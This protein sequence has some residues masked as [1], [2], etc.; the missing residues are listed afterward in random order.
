M[1]RLLL[2]V[3]LCSGVAVFAQQHYWKLDTGGSI[4]WTVRP[5]Q[6]HKDHIEMS[7]KQLSAIVHYG[8]Q[9][10]GALFLSR[11]LVFPM[12][13]TI[14]NDTR[15]N[16]VKEFNGNI[17]DS[18]TIDGRK[19]TEMPRSF[20]IHG[21]LQTT[22]TL[23]KNMILERAVFP[24]TDHAAYIE[25]YILRNLGPETVA[26]NVPLIDS[27]QITDEK[28][29]VYGSYIINT[30]LYNGGLLTLKPQEARRF[31]IVISARKKFEDR[32]YYSAGY[33]FEKRSALVR[34]LENQLILQSPD[35]VINRMFAFAKIRAA[36]SIYETK[37]GLMHGPGGG[38]Y[39]AAIWANDQAEYI[40]P[41]FAYLGN[42][43]GMESARN[44]YRLFAGYMNPAYKPIP[45]SIIAEGA[46]YWNGAGD[47]GD[48]AMIGYGASQFALT[49]GDPV[50]AATLWPLIEWCNTYLL[51]KKTADG[52]I[53]SQSDE[54]EGR[55]PAGKV[56]LSTNTLAY[57]SFLYGS[58]LATALGKTKTAT[59]WQQEAHALRQHMEQYFGGTVEGYQTYKYYEGND[60]LRSWICLPLVMGIYD[61][62]EQ[63]QAALLSPKLWSPNGLLTESGSST[64]WDRSTLYAFRGLFKAGATDTAMAY[65]SF[66]SGKRLLGEHVP[67]AIEAWPEGNQRH[68]S[69]ESGL[70]CRALVEGLLGF[71]PTGFRSFSICPWLPKKWNR[72][73]LKN[74]AAFRTT[75]DLQV[76]RV[77]GKY[78]VIFNEAGKKSQIF[79]WSGKAPL[80]IT[81]P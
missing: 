77:S 22:G 26:V 10:S 8:V 79:S 57:G 27:N 63:T 48:Q 65:L 20:S 23:S 80:R 52:V 67:Y 41:F 3:L 25:S 13:R 17:A 19:I 24:S 16:L 47:R 51:R 6:A 18:I 56:N 44:S 42:A 35:P 32:Y 1:R 45:S 54:L 46:G 73:S 71:E 30:K 68:L 37:E 53:A 55:F 33:E 75:F 60:K 74:I 69:A 40:N 38:E 64:Y 28:K 62:K 11:K 50:E 36:E 66:Y 2:P 39:Y 72:L 15:G 29:G 5:G 76:Q 58:R 59:E 81:L 43:A 31:W 34:N 7:G 4:R 9:P 12:L 61:R 70:Y 21:C 78:R 14:P 49:S